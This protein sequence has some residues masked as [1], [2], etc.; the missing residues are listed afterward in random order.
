MKIIKARQHKIKKK[1]FR[2]DWC[3]SVF[4]ADETEY[5]TRKSDTF[6]YTAYLAECPVCG[7]EAIKLPLF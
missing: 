2:C 5:K 4:I 1:R 6:G 3:K 7:R